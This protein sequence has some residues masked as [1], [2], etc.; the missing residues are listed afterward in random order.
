MPPSALFQLPESAIWPAA[1]PAA[2]R[3]PLIT[4]LPLVVST[5]PLVTVTVAPELTKKP[6][7]EIWIPRNRNAELK[8]NRAR[9]IFIAQKDDFP[10][11]SVMSLTQLFHSLD[12]QAVGQHA[13]Q[14]V[15]HGHLSRNFESRRG[16]LSA[17]KTCFVGGGLP[18]ID[19]GP[20]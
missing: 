4:M 11:M 6:A 5:P 15:V 2:F 14:R 8:S 9:L 16:R 3:V 19:A 7:W 18:V 10:P 13:V 1:A 12:S 20:S 17:R